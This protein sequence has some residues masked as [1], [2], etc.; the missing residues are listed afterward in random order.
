[1]SSWH[2]KQDALR[3]QHPSS[4]ERQSSLDSHWIEASNCETPR[5]SRIFA[6]ALDAR[7][8][9]DDNESVDSSGAPGSSTGGWQVAPSTAK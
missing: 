4:G 5:S 3:A 7:P 1:M 6:E 9:D 8:V 2:A